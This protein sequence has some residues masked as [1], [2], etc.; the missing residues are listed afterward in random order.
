MD[1]LLDLNVWHILGKIFGDLSPPD[2]ARCLAVCRKWN[3]ALREEIRTSSAFSNKRKFIED[4][5]I[6]ML[7]A[8]RLTPLTKYDELQGRRHF[9]GINGDLIYTLGLNVAVF[10]NVGDVLNAD[11]ACFPHT[12]IRPRHSGF[13]AA[14]EELRILMVTRP[15]SDGITSTATEFT[16]PAILVYD[17]EGRKKSEITDVEALLLDGDTF[18]VVQMTT[19]GFGMD[20][21]V[22]MELKML[23]ADYDNAGSIHLRPI[24]NLPLTRRD[25]RNPVSGPWESNVAI[26]RRRFTFFMEGQVELEDGNPF[27]LIYDTANNLTILRKELPTTRYDQELRRIEHGQTNETFFAFVTRYGTDATNPRDFLNVHNAESGN[28]LGEYHGVSMLPYHRYVLGKSKIVY[29]SFH[30][31]TMGPMTCHVLTMSE[32][33]GSLVETHRIHDSRQGLRPTDDMFHSKAFVGTRDRFLVLCDASGVVT[34]QDM[35]AEGKPRRVIY[36]QD[37]VEQYQGQR[38]NFQLEALGEG[39]GGLLFFENVMGTAR[40]FT[41]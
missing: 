26:C 40:L 8:I 3:A 24:C 2:F 9:M 13:L 7:R 14:N 12:I 16:T 20:M 17:N 10:W 22:V 41:K 36:R 33:R 35:D 38:Y 21:D 39:N 18:Y 28:L 37:N 34:V 27:V 23:N 11:R 15:T 6:W 4:E 31:A 5:W 25:I 30:F 1:S 32:D 29:V 19:S